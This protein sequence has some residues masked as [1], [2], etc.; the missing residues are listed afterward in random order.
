M[1]LHR[2]FANTACPGQY[3]IDHMQDI[4]NQVN[5]RLNSTTTTTPTTTKPSTSSN[6]I[7]QIKSQNIG[8]NDMTRGYLQKG[9]RNEAVYAYKQLLMALKK[10]KIISQGVDDNN[11][12][13]AGTVEATKQVQRAAK[14]EVDGLAGSQTMRACYLLLAKKL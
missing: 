2:D 13:G 1:T 9:D 12:Y 4:A 11:I 3:L 14:I 8:G 7:G 6:G 10:A 5:K